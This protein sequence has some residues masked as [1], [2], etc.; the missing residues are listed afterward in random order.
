MAKLRIGRQEE[1]F[2]ISTISI[3]LSLSLFRCSLVK[4][5]SVSVRVLDG[6]SGRPLEETLPSNFQIPAEPFYSLQL[7]KL[8]A[9]QCIVENSR[10]KSLVSWFNRTAPIQVEQIELNSTSRLHRHTDYPELRLLRNPATG[11]G[12]LWSF[13]RTLANENGTFR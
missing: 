11:S 13:T 12:R 1:T 3:Y 5:S 10:P 8:Y 7:N 6:E 9:V 4:P 2:L